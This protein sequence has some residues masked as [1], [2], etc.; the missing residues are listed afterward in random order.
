MLGNVEP[1]SLLLEPQ[2]LILF[3]LVYRDLLMVLRRRLD[4]VA[5]IKDRALPGDLVRLRAAAPAQS[6]FQ[7]PG[8]PA[9]RRRGRVERAALDQRFQR[10]LVCALGVD[11]LGEVPQRL[12]RS[13]LLARR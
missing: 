5:E 7:T 11:P 6:L 9:S 4:L 12:E 10:P 1:Q 3:E 8:H 2:Q 13:P